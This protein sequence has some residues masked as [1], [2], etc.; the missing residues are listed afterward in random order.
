M[1][2]ATTA[3]KTEGS[4][5]ISSSTQR[6]SPL[7]HLDHH[8]R[9]ECI[10]VDLKALSKQAIVVGIKA[11]IKVP[12]KTQASEL[13]TRVR[14]AIK[15]TVAATQVAIK[16]LGA[17]NRATTLTISRVTMVAASTAASKIIRETR[18]ASRKVVIIRVDT[19][20]MMAIRMVARSSL[21]GCQ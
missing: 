15:T 3:T 9:Q 7:A 16:I 12:I 10:K 17:V 6:L 20:A 4:A 11:A 1:T 13:A 8:L 5:T 21:T 2:A 14:T 18:E 19:K